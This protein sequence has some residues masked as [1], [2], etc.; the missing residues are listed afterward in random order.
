M[1]IPHHSPSQLR[2]YTP[3]LE[4][5]YRINGGY[6]ITPSPIENAGALVSGEVL[7][8][9]ERV[10]P[11]RA[12]FAK[13]RMFSLPEEPLKNAAVGSMTVAENLALRTFDRPPLAK[14][15][16]LSSAAMRR[17]ANVLIGRYRIK[18]PS[19]SAPINTL[20]GGNIQRTVLA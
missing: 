13:H 5:L 3:Q 10:L 7:A 9:G 17:Q 19:P 18:T 2:I 16:W 14:G 11:T 1:A 12:A 4:T 20:S 6:A 8:H 15:G